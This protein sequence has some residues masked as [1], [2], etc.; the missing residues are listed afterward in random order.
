[1]PASRTERLRR[2]LADNAEAAALQAAALQAAAD[3]AADAA[4]CRDSRVLRAV[5]LAA[6]TTATALL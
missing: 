6:A 1:M 3:A 2:N 5:L 4:K